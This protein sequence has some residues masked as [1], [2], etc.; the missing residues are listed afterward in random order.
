[1]RGYGHRPGL[2]RAASNLSHTLEEAAPAARLLGVEHPFVRAL[3]LRRVLAR[4]SLTA[5]SASAL[6][7]AGLAFGAGWALPLLV[8]AGAVQLVLA[9]GLAL[10]VALARERARDLFAEGWE[11][12]P[13]PPLARQ[14]RRLLDRRY[15]EGLARAFESVVAKAERWPRI[16]R[17]AR[18]LF[19]VRLV[20]EVAPELLEIAELL[21]VVA[22]SARAVALSERLLT[23]GAS[24]LYGVEIDDLRSELSRIREALR[25]GAPADAAPAAR[26]RSQV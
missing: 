17:T 7:A 9:A 16:L 21:R 4:Q 19:N 12:L 3:E 22:S 15:R 11:H 8:V 26:P 25:S 6:G 20:R 24:P 10:V 2:L 13:L 5:A 14:R 18:P 1:M 23:S